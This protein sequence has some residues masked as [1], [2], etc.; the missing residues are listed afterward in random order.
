LIIQRTPWSSQG[1][2]VYAFNIEKVLRRRVMESF[3]D[4]RF[5]LAR[6]KFAL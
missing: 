1:S 5:S 3:G 4:A 2:A 6:N